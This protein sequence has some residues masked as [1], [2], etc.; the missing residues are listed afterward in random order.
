LA[1][2]DIMTKDRVP[3]LGEKALASAEL[4]GRSLKAVNA[5]LADL[6]ASLRE[7]RE[8]LSGYTRSGAPRAISEDEVR[9]DPS[10]MDMTE[11]AELALAR[12]ALQHRDEEQA[13]LRDRIAEIEAENRR[14]CDEFVAV[15]EQNAGLVGL[16]AAIERLHGAPTRSEVLAAIQEIVINLVGSEELA[17]FELTSDGRRLA[18]AL[19][20]GI[21]RGGLKEIAVGSGTVGRT[22][23]EGKAYVAGDEGALADPEDRHVTACIPLKVGDKATGALAIYGLLG[24][25]HSLTDLDL[26][27]FSLLERHAALALHFRSPEHPTGAR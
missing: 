5:K 12:V 1:T 27:I 19:A 2:E 17:L 6:V 9:M 24:H 16:Y 21:D 11:G 15:Q 4:H 3:G 22:V 20:F 18:P 13:R 7:Q 14:V 23:A 25:K 8:R 10:S 26:E